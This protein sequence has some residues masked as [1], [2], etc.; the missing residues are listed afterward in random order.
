MCLYIIIF[1]HTNIM[2]SDECENLITQLVDKYYEVDNKV[3]KVTLSFDK[4]SDIV[5]LNNDDK[6]VDYNNILFDK[7][8][9]IF[10][11]L[12]KKYKLDVEIIINDYENI[13][14]D[15]AQTLIK[16]MFKLKTYSIMLA[17]KRKRKLSIW[18][19]SIGIGIIF[20]GLCLVR[21]HV[22][23]TVTELV[24]IFGTLLVLQSA[25]QTLIESNSILRA[26]KQYTNKINNVKLVKSS[27][28][29]QK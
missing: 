10:E 9:K 11:I 2:K 17:S 26:D 8:D 24:N 1:S 25:T 28:S 27:Q 18:L 7:L 16:D 14:F 19:L 12:P 6:L 29:K 22:P 21:L 15:Y 3:V 5:T 20:L 4:L 23:E 13:H